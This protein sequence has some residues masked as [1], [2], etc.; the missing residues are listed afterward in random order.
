[1]SI[2]VGRPIGWEPKSNAQRALLDSIGVVDFCL[3]G[4]ALGALKT[5]TMLVDAASEYQNPNLHA[6]L[7]RETETE[8]KMDLLRKARAIYTQMGATWDGGQSAYV[9]PWGATIRFGYMSHEDHIDR[10]YGTE[11][12]YIGVD[13]STKIPFNWLQHLMTRL[14]T[15]DFDLKRRVR[16]VTNPG[17]ISGN[18]HKAVFMGNRCH[19]CF[20]NDPL[21]RKP[22]KV[23]SDAVWPSSG[24]PIN[25]TT[26]F[27]PG[28][29]TDHS[30][31]PA[32]YAATLDGLPDELRMALLEGCWGQFAGQYYTC[33]KPSVHL[34]RWESSDT[35]L[36]IKNI[37]PF[38]GSYYVGCDYGFG[39]S[40]CAA[41]LNVKLA[42][43]NVYTID[44]MVLK[45]VDAP[46]AALM[47]KDRWHGWKDENGNE[48]QILGW[49]L[50]PDSW[51]SRGMRSDSGKSIAEQ[52]QNASGLPFESASNDRM[53]GAML[54]F[55]MLKGG[56]WQICEDTCPE[57]ALAI[58]SRIH[59]PDR[60]EDVLKVKGDPHDDEYDAI[61]YSH[62]SWVQAPKKPRSVLINEFVSSADPNTRA[63]QAMIAKERFMPKS[64]V[65]NYRGKKIGHA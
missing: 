54:L 4:G 32:D 30:L 50:S 33:W 35:V 10:Y 59:D 44:E 41:Y 21:L 31:L 11:F 7:L 28:K 8:M 36:G 57:L 16:F 27:I 9:W 13:E 53:G 64:S 15:T 49:Y 58:P 22:F 46:D 37:C 39:E 52:M 25:R 55:S 42:N 45:G 40:R 62:M 23:Y 26:C 61:R 1:M 24:R 5:S 17:G 51:Q 14:R 12:S 20:P 38:W 18:E 65:L 47:M 29:L 43:G 48:R 6:L 19:H 3:F 2:E 34:T 56:K 60:T 63:M